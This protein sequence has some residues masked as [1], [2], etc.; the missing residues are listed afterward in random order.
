M[1]S[2][3]PQQLPP[4]SST[5]FSDATDLASAITL[6]NNLK[7]YVLDDGVNIRLQLNLAIEVLSNLAS[8]IQ[9]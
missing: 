5:D 7:G 1:P 2:F 8:R 6:V 4:I 3:L 9:E